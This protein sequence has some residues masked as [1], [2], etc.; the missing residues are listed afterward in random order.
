MEGQFYRHP[1]PILSDIY[2]QGAQEEDTYAVKS[3]YETPTFH[4]SFFSIKKD[5]IFLAGWV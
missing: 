3:L 2:K 5:M 1:F 4:I